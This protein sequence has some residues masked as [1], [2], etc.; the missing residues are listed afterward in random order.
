MPSPTDADVGELL[1][2]LVD[3]GVEFIVV[4]GA[5]EELKASKP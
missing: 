2:R 1:R 5:A 3:A 4:G